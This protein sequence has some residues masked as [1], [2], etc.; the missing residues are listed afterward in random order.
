MDAFAG[1]SMCRFNDFLLDR[2]SRALYRLNTGGERSTISIGSRAFE[3]LCL[4]ID[5]RGEF[6]PRRELMAAIWPNAAVEESNLTVQMAALRR[7][8]DVGRAQ[9]AASRPCPGEV[10]ALL[11]P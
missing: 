1:P 10:I 8:L 2:Q 6:V 7:A 11:Y 5:R 3:I 9:K 4:L